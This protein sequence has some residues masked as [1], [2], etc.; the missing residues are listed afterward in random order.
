MSV[1]VDDAFVEGDYWG[2]WKGGGHMQADTLQE[3]HEMADRLGLRRS[4]LQ[5]KPG[6]PWRDHYDL[7]SGKRE[8]A[9]TL[10]AI[11]VTWR[12]AAK[13]NIAA[14]RAHRDAAAGQ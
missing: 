3:L 14:R 4:W 10:G 13:R 6:R 9:I 2:P 7:T 5:S 8:L 1:Y 11:P 12:E